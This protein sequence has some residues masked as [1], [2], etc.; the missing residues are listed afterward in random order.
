MVTHATHGRHN[1]F[2]CLNEALW[3]TYA[4]GFITM[5]NTAKCG[6]SFAEWEDRL[7]HY[8]LRFDPDLVIV[9]VG[10]ND[11]IQN[12]AAAEESKNTARRIVGRVREGGSEVLFRTF[13]LR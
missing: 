3:E 1:W 12:A 7:D 11:A 9:S 13:N 8:V 10:L 6:T 5:I 4:D 2:T